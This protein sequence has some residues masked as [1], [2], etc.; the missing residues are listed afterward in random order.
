MKLR[1]QEE[2]FLE[3]ALEELNLYK[4]HS[5]IQTK[6]VLGHNFGRGEERLAGKS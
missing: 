6:E 2:H 5:T 3:Y 4:Q 1:N